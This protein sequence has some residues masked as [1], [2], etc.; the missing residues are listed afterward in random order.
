MITLVV[1]PYCNACPEFEPDVDKNTLYT[2]CGKEYT[3]TIV[4]CQH[5]KRCEAMIEYLGEQEV[6][7]NDL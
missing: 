3:D 1:K 5:R 7:Q 6:N 2:C 4:R